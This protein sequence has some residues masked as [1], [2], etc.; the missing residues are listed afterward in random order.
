[1]VTKH[2]K[3]FLLFIAGISLLAVN[4]LPHHHHHSTLPCFRIW[5]ENHSCDNEKSHPEKT[6]KTH[7][8][9]DFI[10]TVTVTC[11]HSDNGP[12]QPAVMRLFKE[13]IPDLSLVP[14]TDFSFLL[15][16][17]IE[18]LH[19]IQLFHSLGLRAPPFLIA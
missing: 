14:E 1:M 11:T 9:A 3:I 6:C 10:K 4:I 5:E 17:Y 18:H 16:P 12:L 7:C 2:K 19:G 15:F 8:V 13:N